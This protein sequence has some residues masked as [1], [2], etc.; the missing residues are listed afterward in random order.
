MLF[1]HGCGGSYSPTPP[2][3]PPPPPGNYSWTQIGP[4]GGL[5]AS[6]AFHPTN[7]GE[8]WA[9]GD[10]GG[11]IYKSTDYGNT[12]APVNTG[13]VN[14]ASFSIRFDPSNP[15]RVYAPNYYGRGMLR[16]SD[17]GATWVA[18][19]SGLPDNGTQSQTLE[20]LA[21]N[22]VMTNVIFAATHSGLYKSDDFGASFSLVNTSALSGT[23][24][25]RS[26]SFM[27]DGRL[28]V[29]KGDGVFAVT[30]DNGTTWTPI[31]GAGGVVLGSIS[32]SS[33]AVY[34]GFLNGLILRFAPDFSSA[35]VINDPS[36]PK[37]IATSLFLHV[38]VISGAS[39]TQDTVWVGTFGSGTISPSRWGLFRS[40]DGGSTW[41][42]MMNGMT[43][44]YVFS[45]DVDPH[46]SN[47]V[48]VG[49]GNA[50]G[51][52]HSTNAGASFAQSN[53]TV[54]AT[55]SLAVAQDPSNGKRL[56]VSYTAGGGFGRNF[57]T[58]DGG[59][60]WSIFSDPVPDDG[61][62]SFDIDPLNGNN[63]L[64]GTL[65]KGLWRSTQGVS[66][67]WMQ[68]INAPQLFDRLI[69]D[70]VHPQ[71][72]YAIATTLYVS[73]DGG[74]S[75]SS[76]SGL[77]GNHLAVHPSHGGE[78]ILVTATDALAS[79]DFFNT[80]SSLGLSSYA[81]LETGFTAVSFNPSNPSEVIVGGAK[82]GVYKTTNY[83]PTGAGTTW[84]KLTTPI[85]A[86]TIR[87]VLIEN[88]N[89]NT[90]YYVATFGGSW[91]FLPNSTI[92]LFRSLDGGSTWQELGKGLFPASFFWRFTP[93]VNSP[94]TTFYGGMWGGGFM[95][96]VDT[97]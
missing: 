78:A 77:Q 88:R 62:F 97:M 66:G 5:I 92:G 57:V 36:N 63:I 55:G 68:I 95:R 15:A 17:G 71:N 61:V 90:V 12:W 58:T 30:V 83:N 67:P 72:L 4:L 7:M 94:S 41:I 25:F 9:S 70:R 22:P 79:Q 76:R 42:Q 40:I 11:G 54:N 69:R 20:D 28:L 47:N 16:S 74:A 23:S 1:G 53:S 8:V 48:V 31:L 26:L 81:A 37:S 44:N 86:A 34:L 46:N 84:T 52:F 87:D 35:V 96:L 14:Q 49:S 29:G 39:V 10:D 2:P 19:Q 89:G 60:T 24:D 21:I 32:V 82:G 43:G 45:L 38:K 85:M 18:S 80:R 13:S 73:S 6:V 91:S 3:P 56:I 65:T 33:N 75:F 93:D 64:A 59:G 50:L 27:S 51:I